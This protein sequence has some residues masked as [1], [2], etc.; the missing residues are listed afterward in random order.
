MAALPAPTCCTR[1][2][3]VRP[4]AG[5]FAVK[6]NSLDRPGCVIRHA[7][8]LPRGELSGRLDVSVVQSHAQAVGLSG[9]RRLRATWA[10]VTFIFF[11]A[12][13]VRVGPLIYGRTL[14]AVLIYDD[15]VYYSA[16]AHFIRGMMPYRDF[17]F[18]HPPGIILYLVPF[19]GL[20]QLTDDLVGMAVARLAIAILG[21]ANAVLV[22]GLLK[23]HDHR[24]A[25]IGGLLYAVW[26]VPAIA[27]H[28][29]RLEAFVTFF[30]LASLMCLA[31]G[32]QGLSKWRYLVSGFLMGL[33]VL[34][35]IWAAPIA[36]L[37]FLFIWRTRGVRPA[38]LYATGVANGMA[39]ICLPFIIISPVDFFHHV[40]VDQL[41]RSSPDGITGRILRFTEIGGFR[42]IYLASKVVPSLAVAFL[43]LLALSACCAL[44]WKS[45]WP[46]IYILILALQIGLIAAAPVYFYY[47]F[48][49]L[50]PMIVIIVSAAGAW[51]TNRSAR[52][53]TWILATLVLLIIAATALYRPYDGRRDYSDVWRF[54]AEHQCVWFERASDAIAADALSRQLDRRC[55]MTV[56]TYAV[57]IASGT[58]VDYNS[59]ISERESGSLQG[60]IRTE[61]SLSDA[62]VTFDPSKW[63]LSD[64]T[65]S[66]LHGEFIAV[67][68]S[69]GLTF[70]V[71]T[72][73]QHR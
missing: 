71:R 61:L 58:G 32:P 17:V 19:V 30:L 21:S 36:A 59:T 5:P 69:Q 53:T 54:A 73:S 38:S 41:E 9:A 24:W 8:Y 10:P 56:D 11:I 40:V 64:E 6:L 49:F 33:A 48:A 4:L 70:W 42:V 39:I 12:L 27:E 35:K 23:R 67:A 15:G 29:L 1:R 66:Y 55:W 44:A 14:T 72:D 31:A 26:R 62:A 37:V 13:L 45:T 50:A 25:T 65:A 63:S 22:Y 46:R 52:W 47:Y 18:A 28:T 20:A 57:L 16:S 34:T 3:I 2:L 51:L 68:R 43:V 7:P 60:R